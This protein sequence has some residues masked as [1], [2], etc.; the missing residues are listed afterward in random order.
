MASSSTNSAGGNRRIVVPRDTELT[1]APLNTRVLRVGAN[2]PGQNKHN[3]PILVYFDNDEQLWNGKQIT[4]CYYQGKWAR[5]G[6][7][8]EDD[9][10]LV[11]RALPEISEHDIFRE[12]GPIP[13]DD[14]PEEDNGPDTSD[15]D[16]EQEPDP[17]DNYIRK[18]RANTPTL[19]P[20]Q[21]S[22]KSTLARDLARVPAQIV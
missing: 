11:G 12:T 21:Q 2:T 19:S 7:S 5:L 1:E 16:E 22:P 9:A 4:V 18:S 17:V 8:T 6:H 14:K 3:Y 13:G 20:S 15:S 10:P